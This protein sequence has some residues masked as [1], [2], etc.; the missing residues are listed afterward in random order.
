M[1]EQPVTLLGAK[2]YNFVKEGTGEIIKG[3][4]AF[5]H[6]ANANKDENFIGFEATVSNLPYETFD[7]LKD[8]KFPVSA[9]AIFNIDLAN[10]KNP[11]KLTGIKTAV[12]I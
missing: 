3:T 11:L 8:L 6:S 10:K 2:R 7:E 9:T 1:I 12:K 4:K 5:Y